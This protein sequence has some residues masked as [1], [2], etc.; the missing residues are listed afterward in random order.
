MGVSNMG[1]IFDWWWSKKVKGFNEIYVADVIDLKFQI[2]VHYAKHELNDKDDGIL[3]T[4]MF[5]VDQQILCQD[6]FLYM[7]H[8]DCWP[9]H[10]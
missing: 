9:D 6:L 8:V 2:Y 5:S 10:E 1:G 4:I 7:L 3:E